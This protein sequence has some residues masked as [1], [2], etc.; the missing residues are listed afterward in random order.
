MAAEWSRPMVHPDRLSD[1]PLMN[2][3]L[4]MIARRTPDIFA[5][6]IK[7]LLERRNA[8]PVLTG[9]RC[10]AL[11]LCGRQD[12]W[13]VLARHDE[14]AAMIP[15]SRLIVIE[16]CGHMATME[17]PAAVTAALRDWLTSL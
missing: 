14:M 17:R 11:V 5:A 2:A 12:S 4:D 3:I 15:H 7:A 8:T 6:Q 13:S 9:I 1:T 16:E 10:P